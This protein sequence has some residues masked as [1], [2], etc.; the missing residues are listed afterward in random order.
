VRKARADGQIDGNEQARIQSQ[1]QALFVASVPSQRASTM[2]RAAAR[3]FRANGYD[4]DP[5]PPPKR[6]YEERVQKALDDA[7]NPAHEFTNTTS[8]AELASQLRR[9]HDRT[10]AAARELRDTTPPL[11]ALNA[12]NRLVGG[13]CERARLFEG[14]A[15]TLKTRHDARTVRLMLKDVRN[16]DRIAVLVPNALRAYRDAGYSIHA[17]R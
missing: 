9:A 1:S 15:E 11:N 13:L 10:V 3:T 6:E 16:P 12:Q 7:G 5:K 17:P 8:A 4:V 2:Q 14:Y